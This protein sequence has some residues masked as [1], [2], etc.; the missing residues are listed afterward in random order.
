MYTF[1]K[2]PF[3]LIWKQLLFKSRLGDVCEHMF[4]FLL[5][6]LACVS[7]PC[8]TWSCFLSAHSQAVI[9][10]ATQACHCTHTSSG[11]HSS[12]SLNLSLRLTSPCSHS[13]LFDI[14]PTSFP[15][16]SSNLALFPLTAALDSS[17]V[18][19]L[20]PNLSLLF[21]KAFFLYIFTVCFVWPFFKLYSVR[22]GSSRMFR[23]A[24]RRKG[25]LLEAIE[26]GVLDLSIICTYRKEHNRCS[27]QSIS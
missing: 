19:S 12:N 25:D 6:F 27:G 26:Q 1:K 4:S 21:E 17:L 16:F 11:A 5:A 24:G 9:S 2:C 7:C 8:Y 3:R 22:S 20:T 23:D 18:L 13:A 14:T 15:S 10:L